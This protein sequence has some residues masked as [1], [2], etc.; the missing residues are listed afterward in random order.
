LKSTS[1]VRDALRVNVL[2]FRAQLGLSQAVLAERAG[3]SRA[4]LSSIERGTANPS[5]DTIA[6]IGAVFGRDAGF[7][8]TPINAGGS[9]EDIVRRLN[10]GPEEFADAD[11]LFAVLEEV[12]E[13]MRYSKRGRRPIS[14]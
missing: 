10:D 6:R 4:L 5:I 13:P 11:A 1:P 9:D 2:F 14:A 8:I 12:R 7:L 3:I